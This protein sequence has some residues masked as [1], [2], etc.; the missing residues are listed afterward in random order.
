LS[1]RWNFCRTAEKKIEG[2]WQAVSQKVDGKEML[3]SGKDMKLITARHFMWIYQD[4][5]HSLSLLARKTQRDS[6]TA[7]YDAFGAGAGTYTFVGN[8]YTE[9]IEYFS[10]SNYIGVA[11]DCTMKVEGDSMYQSGKFPMLEGIMKVKDV[12]LEEGYIRIE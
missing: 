12:Q 10:D 11:L 8:T 4:K 9:T 7:Y 3:T 5:R 6:I 1:H 2:V